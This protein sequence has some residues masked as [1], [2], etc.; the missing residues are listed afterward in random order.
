PEI[1]RGR[2]SRHDEVLA[3]LKR[4]IAECNAGRY[5]VIYGPAVEIHVA[6]SRI[7]QLDPLID[8]FGAGCY[9]VEHLRDEQALA[10]GCNL[11]HQDGYRVG[12][13][14]AR[15]GTCKLVERRH[16]RRDNLAARSCDVAHEIIV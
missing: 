3:R 11:V 1:K 6:V 4:D 12:L 14:A 2:A 9:V 13:V 8:S 10:R 15:T 7:V 16:G 5:I